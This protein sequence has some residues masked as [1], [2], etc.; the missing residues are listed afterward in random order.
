MKFISVNFRDSYE[1]KLNSANVGVD[2]EV[3]AFRNEEL[4]LTAVDSVGFW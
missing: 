4:I 1:I 2:A 3:E